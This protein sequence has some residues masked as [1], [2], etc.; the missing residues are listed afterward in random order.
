MR[1]RYRVVLYAALIAVG[2]FA[3]IMGAIY[4][5]TQYYK[6]AKDIAET[7]ADVTIAAN[8]L[9]L[10]FEQHEQEANASYNGKVIQTSGTVAEIA[11]NQNNEVTVILREAGMTNG[12]FCT[13]L[14]A[15]ADAARNL[16]AGDKVTVK[17]QCDGYNG[18]EMMPGDVVLTQCSLVE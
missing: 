11:T 15:A 13:M 2:L 18:M 7:K 12:V 1:H 4:G 8:E 17:G 10:A 16:K 5:I 6:P 14:P 3:I 9:Y